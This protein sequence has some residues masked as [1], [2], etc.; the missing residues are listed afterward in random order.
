V[1]PAPHDLLRLRDPA[2]LVHEGPPPAWAREHLA[3]SPTVVVRR[4]PSRDGLLPVG[5]RG[6]VRSERLAAWLDPADVAGLIRPEDL[7]QGRAWRASG[8]RRVAPLEA[9]DAVAALLE[10]R[11][12]GWG[13]VGGAGFELATGA[14]CLGP[15]SD[16]DLL[17]RAP[18]APDR[19]EARRLVEALARLPVRVD[20]QLEAPGGAVSLAE[21]AAEGARVVLRTAAGPRLVADPW[22]LR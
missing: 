7:A 4:A 8:Q 2:A 22:A 17:V 14:A 3:A 18:A 20:L 12:A 19:G 9:L 21:Y 13:P 11:G 6:A 5:V 15:G 10:E 16:L 1:S